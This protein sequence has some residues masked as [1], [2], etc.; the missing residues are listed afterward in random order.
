MFSGMLSVLELLLFVVRACVRL[1]ACARAYASVRLVSRPEA[2]RQHCAA[3]RSTAQQNSGTEV[4]GYRCVVLV[5][6]VAASEELTFY[7]DTVRQEGKPAETAKA[8]L[9]ALAVLAGG[10]KA[11]SLPAAASPIGPAP[12]SPEAGKEGIATGKDGVAPEA[13]EEGVAEDKEGVATAVG[14]P[15]PFYEK[16]I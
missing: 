6:T 14:E 12:G 2:G 1:R 4:M 8:A 7:R 10:G 16:Y 3:L 9:E 15:A 13:G 5:P 11:A